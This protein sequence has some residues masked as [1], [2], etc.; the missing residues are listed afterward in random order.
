MKTTSRT[1]SGSKSS[2]RSSRSSVVPPARRPIRTPP[3]PTSPP[4]TRKSRRP[5][6]LRSLLRT[7][8]VILC[9]FGLTALV[10]PAL[11]NPAPAIVEIDPRVELEAR[12]TRRLVQLELADVDVPKRPQDPDIALFV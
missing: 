9:V 12:A 4:G 7:S 5:P 11:A 2:G 1:D 10:R 6:R 3:H 8:I